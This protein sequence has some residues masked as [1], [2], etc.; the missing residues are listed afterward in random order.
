[1]RVKGLEC[2]TFSAYHSWIIDSVATYH[3][4]NCS[5]LFT[6]ITVIVSTYV[7]LPDGSI[8]FVTHIGTATLSE[9]LTLTKVLCVPCFTFN[10]ISAINIIKNLRCCLIFLTGYCIH[11]L[12]HWRTI[13]V[14]KEVA[15][16][17]YLLQENKVFASPTSIP[18][19][20][21]HASLD[22]IK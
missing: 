8:A 5:S 17:F 4:I 11:N 14:G 3:M 9:D 19:F 13:G 16:L 20:Q 18:S 10:L 22:S 1:M 2:V 12:Y 7:K 6:S 21:Q 15:G